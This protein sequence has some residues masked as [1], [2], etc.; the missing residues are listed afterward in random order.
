MPWTN[1]GILLIQTIRTNFSEILSE[2]HK[3]SFKEMHFKMSAKWRQ[4]CLSLNVLTN[5]H[6]C[7]SNCLW[8]KSC[9][10]DW[11]LLASLSCYDNDLRWMPRDCTDDKSTLT[12]V[13]AW[14]CKAASHYLS[15]C[16]HKSVSPSGITK[17]QC[18]ESVIAFC[19]WSKGEVYIRLC[20]YRLCKLC[21][22]NDKR[23]AKY[24]M[25]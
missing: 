15:Q 5:T 25:W 18:V 22:I 24:V 4:F 7:I 23:L 20:N 8:I 17:P 13:M 19:T 6:P 2:I 12:Q 16:W 9:F 3:F 10:T 14:C 11:Y 1:A 21:K